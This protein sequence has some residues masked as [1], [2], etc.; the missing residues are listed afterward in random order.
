M[1]MLKATLAL[2]AVASAAP[3]G[4]LEER[5]LGSLTSLISAPL[6]LLGL[7]GSNPL[8][9]L[10]GSLNLSGGSPIS[11]LFGG[12]GHLGGSFSGMNNANTATGS[13]AYN[14]LQYHGLSSGDPISQLLSSLGLNIA[15]P[16]TQ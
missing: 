1:H 11:S 2:L 9:G 3:T 14:T 10:L 13:N 5:Q 16:I 7:G 4:I 8:S 12:L 6:Q 15:S